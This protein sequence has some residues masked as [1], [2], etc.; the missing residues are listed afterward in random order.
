MRKLKIETRRS[1][2]EK[3]EKI[4]LHKYGVTNPFANPEIIKKLQ[5]T[6]LKKYGDA[7]FNNK[8]QTIETL[9]SK[10]GVTHQCQIPEVMLKRTKTRTEKFLTSI[11]AGNRLHGKVIPLWNRDQFTTVQAEYPFQCSVCDTIFDDNMEDGKVPKCPKCYRRNNISILE[12]EFL[13]MLKIN[14]RQKYITPYKVDGINNYK[15]FEFLGD[16][17]HGNPARFEPEEYNKKVKKSYGELYNNTIFKFKSLFDKGYTI[18]Y[19]W[20]ADYVQ[21]KKSKELSFPL[22]IFK[23]DKPI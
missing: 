20:E 3:S 17:W 14:N 19:M 2:R 22:K 12:T 23:P 9:K 18:Y 5:D 1:K 10:Y 13:D 11:F 6:K 7:Y 8:K 4:W 15:I 21:W 16:Y